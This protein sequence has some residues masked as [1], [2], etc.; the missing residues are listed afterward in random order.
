MS[1][2]EPFVVALDD[3]W[4]SRGGRPIID[5]VSLRVARG[6]RVAVLGGNGAG[7]STLLD[8]VLGLLRPSRG[9][10]RVLGHAPPSR[11]VGF[12]PQDPGASLLPWF[13]VRT[14]VLL[15]LRIRHAS[16]TARVRAFDHVRRQV[17]PE[18]HID[19]RARPHQLSGGEQQ[20]VALMRA[21]VGAPRVLVCDEPLSAIDAA[22]RPRLRRTL[23]AVCDAPG[24]PALLFVSHDARDVSGLAQRVHVLSGRPARLTERDDM[25]HGA[26]FAL[27]GGPV[28]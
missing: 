12:V 20:L 21:L 3:V 13:D 5:G 7:K 25:G 2:G 1:A 17:D 16:R 28:P 4:L 19:P 24:G 27:S 10:V 14:N 22:S 9:T 8:A 15:P 11:A 6:D 26:P 18:G 23:R